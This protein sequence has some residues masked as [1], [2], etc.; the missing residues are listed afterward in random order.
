MSNTF[1][2]VIIDCL[3][4]IRGKNHQLSFQKVNYQSL[5]EVNC[6]NDFL[7]VVNT[8]RPQFLLDYI[9]RGPSTRVMQSACLKSGALYMMQLLTPAPHP[10]SKS[11][12]GYSLRQHPIETFAKAVRYLARKIGSP[13]LLPPDVALLAGDASNSDW[14][15]AAVV[16]IYT[17]TP[18][19]FELARIRELNQES[20]IESYALVKDGYI[21]FVD[22]CLAMSFDYSLGNYPHIFETHEYFALLNRFFDGLEKYF[23]LPVI[24]A[25]HPN[26]REYPEYS[27]LFGHRR[28]LFGVTAELTCGC[29]FV[30]SHFSSALSFAVM[31][32]KK[33]LLLSGA[34]LRNSTPGMMIDYISAQLKCPQLD[35]DQEVSNVALAKFENSKVDELSYRMYE[36]KYITNTDSPGQHPYEYLMKYLSNL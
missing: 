28:V 20:G 9:G 18:D 8:I 30:T 12:L 10:V 11:N 35:M 1:R 21:L 27:G 15:N 7:E 36:K 5:Y 24:V 32:R 34:K 14:S 2:V 25:A 13:A 17:A 22:D 4:W 6:E 31:L 16:R 19:F 3:N 26:G 33:I 29:R 23:E